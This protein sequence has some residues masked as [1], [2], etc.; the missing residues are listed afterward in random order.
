MTE[1]RETDYVVLHPDD[2]LGVRDVLVFLD[3][4]LNGAFL[5]AAYPVA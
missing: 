5:A 2:K 1:A 4:A 3:S